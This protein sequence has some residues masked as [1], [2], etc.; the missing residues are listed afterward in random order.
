MKDEVILFELNVDKIK[1]KNLKKYQ[2]IPKYPFITR[3]ISI[4]VNEQLSV[5]EVLD[6]IKG[7]KSNLIANISFFDLF[8]GKGIK[9]RIKALA[10]RIF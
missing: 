3:D 5:G 1:H 8:K 9:K 2:N 7:F 10:Y 4:I 6:K